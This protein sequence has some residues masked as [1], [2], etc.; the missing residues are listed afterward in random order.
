[1]Q[2]VLVGVLLAATL[3][4]RPRGLIGEKPPSSRR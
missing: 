1:L 3:I 2:I 4:W